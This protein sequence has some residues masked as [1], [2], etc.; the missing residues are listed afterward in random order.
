MHTK[1]EMI[2]GEFIDNATWLR[3]KL[4]DTTKEVIEL[5]TIRDK[6]RDDF[7]F[8]ISV[9]GTG[10]FKYESAIMQDVYK[11]ETL[12][13]SYEKIHIDLYGF[14]TLLGVLYSEFQESAP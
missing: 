5:K 6:T 14:G 11:M 7:A 13:T 9:R 10:P 4:R 2:T 8:L 3:K 1:M 12:V